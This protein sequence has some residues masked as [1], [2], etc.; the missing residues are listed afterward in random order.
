MEAA[1]AS[2]RAMFSWTLDMGTCVLE[3]SGRSAPLRTAHEFRAKAAERPR[4]RRAWTKDELWS[5]S[6]QRR[7]EVR[8]AFPDA[9]RG[10]QRVHEVRLLHAAGDVHGVRAREALRSFTRD[11]ELDD[12][13]YAD[14]ASTPKQKP[15]LLRWLPK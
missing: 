6:E 12:D 5:N 11:G 8:R 3:V 7:P 2:A 1:S 14:I 9:V 4:P 10:P 15:M 13:A